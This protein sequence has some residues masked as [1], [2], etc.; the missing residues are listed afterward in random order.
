MFLLSHCISLPNPRGKFVVELC[1]T[2]DTKRM[3]MISRRE[4]LDAGNARMLN[5]ARKN[6]VTDEIVSAH[7]HGDKGHPYLKGNA[8][9]FWQDSTPPHIS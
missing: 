5:P 2:I 6:K 1:Q 9:L 7:L 3:Q 4:G 8:R